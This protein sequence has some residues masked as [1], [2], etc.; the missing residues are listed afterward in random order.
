MPEKVARGYK[1]T[2]ML[3]YESSF[4]VA[5]STKA[6]VIL[7]I[8]SFGMTASRNKNSAQT[9]RGRRDPDMPFDGNVET[10][11]DVVVPIDTRAFGYWLKLLFGAP[12]TTSSSDVYTHVFVPG[13]E[14]PS[15]GIQCSYGTSPATYG[16][17]SGCKISSLNFAAGGDEELTAT[18]SMAGK[19]ANFSTTNYDSGSAAETVVLKRLSNFQAKLKWKVAAADAGT[20]DPT[21]LTEFAVC[22]GFDMT[23][24]NGLDTDTR[25]LGSAGELYDLPEGIMSV[26]GNVTCLFTSLDLLTK[27]QNS[28]ELALELSFTIDS[29][30]KLTFLFPEVQLQFQGPTVEG[31]TGIRTQYPFVAYFNDATENTVC[32]VTLVND[33][34]EY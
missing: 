1:T 24:D 32:K 30:N 2:C 5:P 34:E 31:P 17:F 4:G 16:M 3:D 11:G 21:S 15:A 13:D 27:A 18:I 20:G 19:K 26:S 14:A 8:N 10:S 6:P 28:N 7:P 23:F 29:D 22:T 33:V 12:T 9:L 25:T